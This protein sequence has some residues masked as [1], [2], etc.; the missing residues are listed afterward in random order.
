MRINLC[1][2]ESQFGLVLFCLYFLFRE[3]LTEQFIGQFYS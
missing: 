2:V 1:F 3:Y